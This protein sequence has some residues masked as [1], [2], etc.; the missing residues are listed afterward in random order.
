VGG[1]RIGC[2]LLG[3]GDKMWIG[4]AGKKRSGK[5]TIGRMIA[6]YGYIECA[7][8]DPI[9]RCVDN[10][11][12]WIV[13]DDNKDQV[14]PGWE[15]SPRKAYQLFG[16]EFGRALRHDLWTF[17]ADR[18]FSGYKNV[19]VTDIRFD[20]EAEWIRNKGGVVIHLM[21]E[22]DCDDCHESENGITLF[23]SEDRYIYNNGTLE[24]TRALVSDIMKGLM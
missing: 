18:Y 5:S 6:R 3:Y 4:L 13:S 12:C 10:L 22:V 16:T 17:Y 15:F 20:D 9:K 1:V 8:A 14:Y 23:S 24:E 21:R 2:N 11:F 7:L 19:V